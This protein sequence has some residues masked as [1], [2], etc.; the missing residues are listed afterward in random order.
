LISQSPCVLTTSV[1]VN[2]WDLLTTY[3]VVYTA[4]CLPWRIAFMQEAEGFWK[5]KDLFM[6]WLFY[7]DFVLNFLTCYEVKGKL[8]EK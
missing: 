8:V 5:V 1:Y 6:D 3:F 4:L 2:S 7:A